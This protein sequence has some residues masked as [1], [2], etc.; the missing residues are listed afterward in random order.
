MTRLEDA[1]RDTL[2][3]PPVAAAVPADPLRVLQ[4]RLRR[5]RRARA[6]LGV[7]VT[8]VA[9]FATLGVG[10]LVRPGSDRAGPAAS[11][12]PPAAVVAAARGLLGRV[13][14]GYTVTGPAEWVRTTRAAYQRL[15]GFGGGPNQEVYVVQVHGRFTCAA[16]TRQ[17]GAK[18]PTGSA[19]TTDAPVDG[20]N[21]LD[22]ADWGIGPPVDLSRLG[23]VHTFRLP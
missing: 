19:V 1:V 23:P 9:V 21:G 5:R 14:P 12:Q 3:N 7:G 20:R 16:C 15:V 2:H 22:F 17:P 18:A 13:E 10:A 4:G 6:M 11:S 8:A